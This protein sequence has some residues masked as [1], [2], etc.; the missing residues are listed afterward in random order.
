MDAIRVSLFRPAQQPFPTGGLITSRTRRNVV[1]DGAIGDSIRNFLSACFVIARSQFGNRLEMDIC[2][3]LPLKK[4][5]R[6]RIPLVVFHVYRV[7]GGIWYP[8][9]RNSHN[10]LTLCFTGLDAFSLYCI[11]QRH[12]LVHRF[13]IDK[14]ALLCFRGF[15]INKKASKDLLNQGQAWDLLQKKD[16]QRQI[17]ISTIMCSS[18]CLVNI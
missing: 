4:I 15:S 18:K 8:P 11:G 12:V 10:S 14:R 5:K 17:G 3:K 7:L 2:P 6:E 13:L 16:K 9:Y 1:L